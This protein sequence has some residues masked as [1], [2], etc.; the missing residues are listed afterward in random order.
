MTNKTTNTTI[1]LLILCMAVIIGCRNKARAIRSAKNLIPRDHHQTTPESA[2]LDSAEMMRILR[3]IQ[4]KEVQ[5]PDTASTKASANEMIQQAEKNKKPNTTASKQK[6]DNK[7]QR[8]GP[9][10]EFEELYWD[11]GEIKEGDVVKK[12]FTFTNTGD[13]PLVIKA[14]RATCGCAMPSIPF[15]EIAPGESDVIGV[16]YNSVGK[17]GLQN[18][19]VTVE[20]N[21][22]PKTTILKLHGMV[23]PKNTA[24]NESSERDTSRS[25]NK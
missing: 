10:I 19:E 1:L 23:V 11:F 25:E 2:R 17:D 7:K 12:G 6:N 5:L 16:T 15:L 14:T 18:P 20:S 22:H 4:N 24:E 3:E 21:T 13:A 8:S 9:K